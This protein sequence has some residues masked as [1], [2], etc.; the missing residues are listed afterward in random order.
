MTPLVL[1]LWA[2]SVAALAVLGRA[3]PKRRRTRGLPPLASARRG[4]ALGVLALCGVGVAAGAGPAGALVWASAVAAAGWAVTRG[5]AASPSRLSTLAGWLRAAQPPSTASTVLALFALLLA[6]EARRGG[7][8][9]SDPGERLAT[10]ALLERIDRGAPARRTALPCLAALMAA[11]RPAAL[12]DVLSDRAATLALPEG[13]DAGADLQRCILAA[14][15]Q[16][17]DVAHEG[18]AALYTVDADTTARVHALAIDLL[19]DDDALATLLPAEGIGAGLLCR[20]VGEAVGPEVA[21]FLDALREDRAY[22]KAVDLLERLP[23]L[24]RLAAARR[25]GLPCPA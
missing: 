9:D 25:A 7:K 24:D 12:R 20:R 5:L 8:A 2:V 14:G 4:P 21:G 17:S 6:V 18:G 16:G 1:P 19:L 10:L 23:A 13:G 15:G 22:A 3:D 11:R